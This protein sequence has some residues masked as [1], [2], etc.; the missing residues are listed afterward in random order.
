MNRAH[1]GRAKAR[2]TRMCLVAVN[3]KGV[4][5]SKLF[6][7]INP[8]TDRKNREVPGAYRLDM[9]SLDSA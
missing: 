2:V 6:A 8:N 5:P 4:R 9:R 3:T 7:E 1:I